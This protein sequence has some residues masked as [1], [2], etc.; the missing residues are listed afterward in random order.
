VQFFSS[1]KPTKELIY[2]FYFKMLKVYKYERCEP[3]NVES[4]FEA[5]R[6]YPEI[7][8]YI[9]IFR[10]NLYITKEKRKSYSYS[11]YLT[12]VFCLEVHS[13]C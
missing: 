3:E 1:C 11:T 13:D 10:V 9:Y 12:T 2:S 7:Y 5:V 4:A 8:I 6:N